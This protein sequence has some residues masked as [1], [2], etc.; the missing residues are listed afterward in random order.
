MSEPALCQASTTE[1]AFLEARDERRRAWC[2]PDGRLTEFREIALAAAEAHREREIADVAAALL[3]LPPEQ[4]RSLPT[5]AR[6][7][8]VGS[9]MVDG[10]L[11]L[12]LGAQILGH[13]SVTDAMWTQLRRLD[14]L[15]QPSEQDVSVWELSMESARAPQALPVAYEPLDHPCATPPTQALSSMLDALGQAGW[16]VAGR[17]LET[18]GGDVQLDDP[19]AR[20][21]L[22]DLEALAEAHDDWIIVIY[23]LTRA[24]RDVHGR[25]GSMTF[26]GSGRSSAGA[27]P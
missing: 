9:A 18:W 13:G 17:R 2:L 8:F 25:D 21:V 16:S 1:V 6:R 14:G 11:P 7:A 20:D 24:R 26:A 19:L 27:W 15:G 12:A 23:R 3:R 10:R 22:E 5:P 4:S